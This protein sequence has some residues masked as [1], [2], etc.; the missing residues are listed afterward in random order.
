MYKV[1]KGESYESF[2]I[3]NIWCAIYWYYCALYCYYKG[4]CC[5]HNLNIVNFLERRSRQGS[6]SEWVA[7]EFYLTYVTN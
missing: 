3:K 2:Q 5:L 4:K 6:M 1:I 7:E